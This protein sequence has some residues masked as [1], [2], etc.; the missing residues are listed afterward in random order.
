MARVAR[1]GQGKE[2]GAAASDLIQSP[3][4]TGRRW[5]HRCSCL[6]LSFFYL[7]VVGG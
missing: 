4:T 6:C 5:E 2:E 3:S 1:E 7:S